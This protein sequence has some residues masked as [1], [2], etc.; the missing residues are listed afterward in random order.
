MEAKQQTNFVAECLRGDK[1]VGY[2]KERKWADGAP[3][4]KLTNAAERVRLGALQLG[5]M[6]VELKKF[7]QTEAIV[8][9]FELAEVS[10]ANPQIQQLLWVH[11]QGDDIFRGRQQRR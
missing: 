8:L 4:A 3:T 2:E 1:R 10:A 6:D 5:K 7:L 9:F 11:L